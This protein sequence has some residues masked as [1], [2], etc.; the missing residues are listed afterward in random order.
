MLEP[1]SPPRL[2]EIVAPGQ[3]FLFGMLVLTGQFFATALAGAFSDSAMV[4]LSAGAIWILAGPLA[5]GRWLKVSLRASFALHP[6]RAPQAGWC[7]LI[8]AG[9]VPSMILLGALNSQWIEPDQLFLEAMDKLQPAGWADWA[10]L[11]LVAVILVP[12]AEELLFRGVLQESAQ[13]ALGAMP[14]AI[15]V[16]LIFAA[17]HFEPWYLI[18]LS[19]I[20]IVL[21]LARLATGSVIATAIVHGSYN[22]GALLIA[23]LGSTEGAASPLGTGIFALTALAGVYA[24][25]FSL[26]RLQPAEGSLPA[27]PLDED[28]GMD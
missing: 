5:L 2:D 23:E 1:V 6:V 3:R 27:E 9:L 20:G 7:L 12:L 28:P 21:G 19:V 14:A 25:W 26:G 18:P 10:S 4:Q 24:I 17:A 11:V 13:R 8:G 15:V 22:L 16:G